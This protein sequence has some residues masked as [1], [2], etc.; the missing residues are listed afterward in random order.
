MKIGRG[1]IKLLVAAG[2]SLMLA[3]TLVAAV[4]LDRDYKLGD[5]ATE[6][7]ITGG[8]VTTTFDSAGLTG[9]GQL[10]DLT[11]VHSP[12]YVAISG[13]PDG[14]GGRGIQFSSA[15]QQY[16]HGFNL[17]YPQTSFSAATHTTPTGG[18][19]DY[20][21][22]SDRG[23][24]FWARPTSTAVQ[25]LVMDTNQHGVRIDSNGKFAMRY[26]NVD[27][28]SSVSVVPNSWYH[29][30]VVRPAGAANGSRMY[31]NGVAVA[32][33]A[34][35]Y[36]DDWADVVVG[37]NTA[38]DDG[39]TTHPNIP[40][41]Q[42]FTG[43]TQEFYSG[44]IDDLQMFVVGTS[45][46]TTP[47][48]YGT[49]NFATDNAFAASPISGLKN[50]AGDVTNNGVFDVNDKNAFIAGWLQ[51]H[52]VNGVQIGD[53][54]SHAQGDLNLDGITNIQDLLLM[55]NALTGAGLG[56]ITAAQL[57]G[58]PEPA[59]AVLVVLALLPL[60]IGRSRPRHA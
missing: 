16:L 50:V 12:T 28:E 11:A 22:I 18:S 2:L 49:F 41:P 38:G 57:S 48:N 15:Q 34:G 35:G 46:S 26:A 36:N 40:T 30:E 25:T 52:V 43:G 31:I 44:I 32:I 20:L 27:Y 33:A 9:Q 3:T 47:V 39:G 8:S 1:I 42:G 51:K 19:L 54:A 14:V 59:T 10:V 6:G 56:T 17:G 45:T 53:I 7:A 29:I 55:Q 58:V 13:R 21:G 4:T 23:F 24:Q 5:D 60:A 37:S